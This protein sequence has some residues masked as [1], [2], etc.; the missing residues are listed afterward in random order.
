MWYVNGNVFDWA[1]DAEDFADQLERNGTEVVME[2]TEGSA[3]IQEQAHANNN[4]NA[5]TG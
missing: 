4:G 1:R 3:L 5:A 2:Y